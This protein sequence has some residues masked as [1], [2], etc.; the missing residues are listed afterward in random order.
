MKK[1][2]F[3]LTS[4]GRI[5]LLNKTLESFFKFNDYALEKMYLVEDSFNQNVY[6]EIKKRWGKKL[7]LLFNEK[8]K[9]QI[10]SI[11][12]TY[13]LVKTPLIFH[14]EDDWLYTRKNFIQDCLKI[15]DSD[16]KII[17]VWLESKES[18][19]RLDIFEY[20]PLQKVGN[21]GFRKVFCKE[22][23]EWGYFSF[24]P[25]IKRLSDYNLIGGY[26][27][28]KNELDIGVEYKKRG[29]Y[30]VIIENPAVIDIGDDHHVSDVTRKWPK[31]R[32][33]GAPTGLKRLWKHLKS[34][35][36]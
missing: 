12:E 10:K 5:E 14:C 31:R 3:V 30:T 25:G 26:D 33:A 1:I 13:K 35:K 22:G 18:A 4:C 20:G 23:W 21:V 36:F 11:V 16:E 34:F 27:N 15:M 8:K 32:K 24:R 6:S 2:T 29:Y 17:Q 9:G 19:S 7:T 28:F